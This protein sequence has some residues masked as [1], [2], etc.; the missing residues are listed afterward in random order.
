MQWATLNVLDFNDAR[1]RISPLDYIATGGN[2]LIIYRAWRD[3]G[4]GVAGMSALFMNGAWSGR[5]RGCWNSASWLPF[6]E[7]LRNSNCRTLVIFVAIIDRMWFWMI[8][9]SYFLNYEIKRFKPYYDKWFCVNV[10]VFIENMECN[11][12]HVC[13]FMS[14]LPLQQT[15]FDKWW[16]I[17]LMDL[18][19]KKML[20]D[21]ST[22]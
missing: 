19:Q 18:G 1:S 21:I 6:L 22:L 3:Y 11:D 20:L 14:C 4:R 5:R 7:S 15:K 16:G 2:V 9:I 8:H 13:F 12:T 17:A 10:V